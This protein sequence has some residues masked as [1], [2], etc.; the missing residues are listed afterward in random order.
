MMLYKLLQATTSD[1]QSKIVVLMNRGALSKKFDELEVEIEYLGLRRGIFL[2]PLIMFRMLSASRRFSPDVIQ[3]WMYHG[4]IS[5]WLIARVACR[6][7][8]LIWN[9]RQT[10]YDLDRE[11]LTTRW[12]IRL[13]RWFSSAPVKIIYNSELSAHQHESI[14]YPHDSRVLIPNGFDLGRFKPDNLARESINQE[15][16][17]DPGAPLV[18]HTA[19]YHPMKDHRTMLLAVKR[20]SESLAAA[21]FLLVGHRVTDENQELKSLCQNLGLSN[22]VILGGERSDL[23]RLMAAADV[24]V[25][26][27]A[28]GEGFPNVIGEAMACCTPCVVTDVGDSSLIVGDCGK[29]V[30]SQ[31]PGALATAIIELLSDKRLL[32]DLGTKARARIQEF[33]SIEKISRSYLDLYQGVS[34]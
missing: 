31:D 30:P 25:L 15:F 1:L 20:V 33:Y 7:A 14:G 17:L 28:W 8:K 6:K 29:V 22:A 26:S 13:S 19:R 34:V 9:I 10:L 21:R 32:K 27:S 4:N 12:L 18:V 24:A 5:V 2:N 16:G 23:P 11:K 3:G